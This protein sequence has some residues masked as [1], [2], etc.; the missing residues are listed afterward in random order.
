M[1]MDWRC[2]RTVALAV[3]IV[4]ICGS[5]VPTFAQGRLSCEAIL[6]SHKEEIIAAAQAFHVSPRMLASVI[7]AERQLNRR[8]GEDVIDKVLARAG[9]NSS[10]GLAQVKVETAAWILQELRRRESPCYLGAQAAALISINCTRGELISQLET[11]DESLGPGLRKVGHN[12]SNTG[13][14]I[15]YVRKY[16]R[17]ESLR[18]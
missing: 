9:Y 13:L 2:N 7:Y 12:R 14:D 8:P 17:M 16:I 10:V 1:I 15:R 11:W 3:S 4:A 5:W 18:C 6:L